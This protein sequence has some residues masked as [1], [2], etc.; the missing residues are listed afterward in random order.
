MMGKFDHIPEL[1]GASVFQVWKTQIVLALGREGVYNHISDG[2]DPTDFTELASHLPTPANPVTP[3]S[4]ER[5]LI[6]DWLKDD[7]IAKDIISR[8]AWQL[9]HSHLDHIDLGSQYLVRE[10]ILGLQMKDAKDAQRY[11][12]EH[13]SLRRDL[14]QMQVAYTD[15]E[16]IFN[17]LKGGWDP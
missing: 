11:L 3:T 6:Q 7:A 13:D 12:G 4:D 5:K 14:I 17:L 2:M 15:S 1:T 9:L 8:N 16:A 10:K